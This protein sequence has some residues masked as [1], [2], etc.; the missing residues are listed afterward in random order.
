M[1]V[2]LDK[3]LRL[4]HG[5]VVALYVMIYTLGRGW[6]E[7]LRVDDVQL[8][9][10]LGL[11]LNVW[12][13]ILMFTLAAAYFLVSSNR[14]P[15]R[16]TDLYRDGWGP[17]G[18]IDPDAEPSEGAAATMPP[19]TPPTSTEDTADTEAGDTETGADD[20]GTGTGKVEA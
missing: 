7:L 5:R 11:R 20:S 12:T 8:D 6:I 16:E 19:G 4:G 14:H 13:S 2:W 1:I 10:V 18:R 17:E 3:R 15:G 9:D